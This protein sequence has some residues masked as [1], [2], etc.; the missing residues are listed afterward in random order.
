MRPS[1]NVD[2]SDGVVGEVDIHK[3]CVIVLLD[4]YGISEPG[5]VL[6]RSYNACFI[7]VDDDVLLLESVPLNRFPCYLPAFDHSSDC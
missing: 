6:D 7:R 1:R 3:I 4:N 2:A 5:L